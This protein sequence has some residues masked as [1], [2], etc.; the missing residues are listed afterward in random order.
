MATA[1][2]PGSFDPPTNGHLS[3]I[4]RA[5][6]LFDKIDVVIAVNPSKQHLFSQ[7]ERYAMMSELIKPYENVSLYICDELIVNYAQKIGANVL[8]RGIR[9]VNDF[10]YEF[11][12][13]LMNNMLNPKMETL[14]IPTERE[15]VVVKSSSIK[16]LAQF[17][18]DISYMVPPIVEDALK[19]KFQR[20][21][22][23]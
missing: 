3:I 19:K 23:K 22:L 17:G 14:F 15:Y 4:K 18:G 6:K 2:F 16:E 5:S 13:A 12:L 10:S 1:V 21:N 7:D 8:L 20:Y 11:D 9:S